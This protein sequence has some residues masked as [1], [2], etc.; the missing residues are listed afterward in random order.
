MEKDYK[1]VNAVMPN[2]GQSDNLI[3]CGVGIVHFW[4]PHYSYFLNRVAGG[5]VALT[6]L[7]ITVASLSLAICNDS[8]N[9]T[10]S[11]FNRRR[12]HRP[13]PELEDRIA[14]M[15]GGRAGEGIVYKGIVST[16]GT[17]TWDGPPSSGSCS[18][19]ETK[20]VTRQ[21]D[22]WKCCL[23]HRSSATGNIAKSW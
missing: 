10:S 15:V 23:M 17:M 13:K 8:I 11:A 19:R 22:C 14:V 5:Q 4:L 12:V 9:Q 1:T 2:Q 7:A 16:G 3:L 18:E 20:M 21:D 6:R